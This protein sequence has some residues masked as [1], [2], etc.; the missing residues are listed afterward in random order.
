MHSRI[1]AFIFIALCVSLCDIPSFANTSDTAQSTVDSFQRVTFTQPFYKSILCGVDI[2]DPEKN[3]LTFKLIEN[4]IHAHAQVSFMPTQT[5]I[6]YSA[7]GARQTLVQKGF[8]VM[9]MGPATPS[10]IDSPSG[11]CGDED[12][13][14]ENIK[15]LNSKQV[16]SLLN[17]LCSGVRL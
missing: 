11:S 5:T 4:T 12:V 3:A 13:K 14:I 10:N 8:D 1:R 6:N 2:G 17:E 7:G 9:A 16:H 15:C